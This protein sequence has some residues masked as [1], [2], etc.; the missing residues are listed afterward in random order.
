MSGDAPDADNGLGTDIARSA[1]HL[2]TM[3]IV[4]RLWETLQTMSDS[5]A[6]SDENQTHK[7]GN[8][9]SYYYPLVLDGISHLL[10]G[11]GTLFREVLSNCSRTPLAFVVSGPSPS[12]F[13][14]TV[15]I[16]IRD[17]ARTM[18]TF[19]EDA[20][21]AITR[22]LLSP[23]TAPI[24]RSLSTEQESAI[25]EAPVC[26]VETN[27]SGTLVGYPPQSSKEPALPFGPVARHRR[28]SEIEAALTRGLERYGVDLSWPDESADGDS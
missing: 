28:D 22:S 15:A 5:S 6:D 1:T 8:E 20:T 27:R 13:S 3:T 9:D 18:I 7:P 19:E 16:A 17:H 26:W 4:R 10:P 25:G 21:D 14:D 12:Q 24:E 11:A 2:L 23:G